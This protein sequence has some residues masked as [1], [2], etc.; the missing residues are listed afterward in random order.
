MQPPKTDPFGFDS[1]RLQAP[2]C[3]SP[4]VEKGIFDP[5]SVGAK[6]GFPRFSRV[7]ERMLGIDI[8]DISAVPQ[9]LWPEYPLLRR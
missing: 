4:I 5:S 8:A 9:E 6:R 2:R 7:G 3:L 1:Q